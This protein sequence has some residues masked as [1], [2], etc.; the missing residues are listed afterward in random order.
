MR[1]SRVRSL[2]WRR[3]VAET[4][5]ATIAFAGVV[6]VVVVP[7]LVVVGVEPEP[8]PDAADGRC[9]TSRPPLC[10]R[11][12][13]G[14]RSARW[15]RRPPAR[16]RS[17]RSRRRSR[18]V[19]VSLP[20]C[21]SQ[22]PPE[23]VNT[24]AAPLLP[25]SC[26]PPIRAVEPSPASATLQP[27]RPLPLSPPPVS[28]PPCWFQSPPER[29]NTQAAPLLSSSSGPPIRAVEPSAASATLAPKLPL[30]L[31]PLPVSLPPCWL[32]ADPERVNAQAAPLL[33]SSNGPPIRAVLPSAA[34]ATLDAEA[35]V[36]RSRRCRSACRPAGP[37]P[38]RSG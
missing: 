23:R 36:C 1:T 24:Q 4:T 32:Q 33:P 11:R 25:P 31:S 9:R 5:R 17:R 22:P 20:P 38:R 8:P 18:R 26:G 19:P 16:R 34:S 7:V 28:L 12:R 14:R 15:S 13:Q 35:A 30:P 10:G 3:A 2:P 37:S 29:V 6:L 27:K 21:W